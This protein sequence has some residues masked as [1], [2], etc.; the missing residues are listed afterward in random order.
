MIDRNAISKATSMLLTG[1]LASSI[2]ALQVWAQSAAPTAVQAASG[3]ANPSAQSVPAK[4]TP[5][6]RRPQAAYIS[7]RAQAY[8]A[9][10]WGVQDLSVKAAESGEI[11]RFSWTVVD[12]D[13]ARTI[14]DKNIEP[15]LNDPQAGVQLVVPSLENVGSLR[16]MSTPIAGKTYWMAFSNPGRLVKPGHHVIVQI[17]PFHADNL[18][19]E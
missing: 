18:F 1:I 17:G 14:H 19:V 5:A 7:K 2:L 9:A 16:Q 6:P 3:T 11:I 4:P 13:L 10:A 8:Y 12:P 15:H